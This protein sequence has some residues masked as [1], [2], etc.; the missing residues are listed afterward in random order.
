MVETGAGT[1]HYGMAA[2]VGMVWGGKF[3]YCLLL[4]YGRY[5]TSVVLGRG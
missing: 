1:Y 5:L 4:V 3:Q 2:L